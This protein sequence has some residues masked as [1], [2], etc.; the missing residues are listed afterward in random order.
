MTW[1]PSYR[2]LES[3]PI[4]T[5]ACHAARCKPMRLPLRRTGLRWITALSLDPLRRRS[6]AGDHAVQPL[7]RVVHR[8]ELRLVHDGLHCLGRARIASH[9]SRDSAML[10]P[11]HR[12]PPKA[13]TNMVTHHVV[14]IN[15]LFGPSGSAASHEERRRGVA[16][17]PVDARD[18]VQLA[19]ATIFTKLSPRTRTLCNLCEFREEVVE[20]R[21]HRLR[22]VDSQPA[23]H[24]PA[25]LRRIDEVGVACQHNRRDIHVRDPFS[26]IP[27][28]LG[29]S[30]SST[31][32]VNMHR[33][34]IEA[35]ATPA[36][37]QNG[38]PAKL[39]N[40]KLMELAPDDE[41]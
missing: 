17:D 2:I 11:A 37:P 24:R 9:P 20:K 8:V 38:H 23:P 3:A 5:Q 41:N 33:N 26:E 22:N 29:N 30:A 25:A 40:V 12:A 15:A 35:N 28:L 18:S 6:D 1:N 27:K 10:G 39:D 32:L 31:R 34:D 16:P 36:R 14:G 19:E 13:Q 7:E 21:R 4:A